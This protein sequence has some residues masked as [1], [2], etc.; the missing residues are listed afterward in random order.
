MKT[1]TRISFRN[2]PSSTEVFSAV[3]RRAAHVRHIHRAVESCRVSLD[4]PSRRHRSGNPLRVAVEIHA[5]GTTLVARATSC[6]GEPASAVAAINE[7]FGAVEKQL[8]DRLARRREPRVAPPG[9]SG[10]VLDLVS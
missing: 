9:R 7:A 4:R 8:K 5:A 3:E 2:I 10:E 6:D 1:S